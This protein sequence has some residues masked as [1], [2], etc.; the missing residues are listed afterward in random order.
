VAVM[1]IEDPAVS[2]EDPEVP[3]NIEKLVRELLLHREGLTRQVIANRTELAPNTIASLL[4]H[5]MLRETGLVVEEREGK[6]GARGGPRRRRARINSFGLYVACVEVAHG[7]VRCG[8][9]D[10][11]GRL[12]PACD[13]EE[14]GRKPCYAQ[15]VGKD[16]RDDPPATLDFIEKALCERVDSVFAYHRRQIRKRAHESGWV[17]R[18]APTVVSVGISAAGPVDPRDGKLRCANPHD[19][20]GFSCGAWR[21]TSIGHSLK[22]RFEL[23]EWKVRD[24]FTENDA[25]LCAKAELRD[26]VLRRLEERAG[27]KAHAI[28]VKWTGGVGGAVVVN[29]Q[30]YEGF[31]GFAGEFGHSLFDPSDGPERDLTLGQRVGIAAISRRLRPL[32][33]DQ[34][35]R[36]GSKNGVLLRDWFIDNVLLLARTGEDVPD[37]EKERQKALYKEALARGGK[38]TE[39][40]TPRKELRRA[41]RELGRALV[42]L[43]DMLNPQVI[44]ISGGVFDSGDRSLI[45][46]PLVKSLR[47]RT[48]PISSNEVDVAFGEHSEHPA[49]DGAIASRLADS[50]FPTR[51]VRAASATATVAHAA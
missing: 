18:D 17:L 37:K 50:K 34:F 9:S 44:V 5:N 49:L 19:D 30:V 41:A 1:A 2:T 21:G 46:D 39:V 40:E 25:N 16:A 11:F 35:R 27:H 28:V 24:F 31:E 36:E 13:D 20:S 48:S 7:H 32:A 23:R 12:L 47:D 26:G 4:K 43:V 10:V 38:P 33:F 51:L 14:A 45:V 6:A 42:P 15:R 8:V 22:A 29:G 3:A